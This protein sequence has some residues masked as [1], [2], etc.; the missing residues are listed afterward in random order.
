MKM[1]LVNPR[2]PSSLWGFQGL[3]DLVGVRSGQ[4]PLGL[5]TVAGM[6]PPEIDLE[7]QDENCRPLD[8][9]TGADVVAIG[10]DNM[11]VEVMPNPDRGLMMPVHQH[12]LAEAGVY[13]IENLAL[14]EAARDRLA[15]D[16][17][18]P[19]AVRR[20]RVRVQA[21]HVRR[22]DLLLAARRARRQHHGVR[23]LLVAPLQSR[24]G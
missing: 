12:V 17:A 11:A 10:C 5:V 22:L 24:C 16:R 6:T 8:L 21:V 13:L 3:S 23:F 9:E 20:R 7:L 18:A 19:S 4:A 14:E 1:L 15:S 2:F